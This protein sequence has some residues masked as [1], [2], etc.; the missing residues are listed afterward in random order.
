MVLYSVSAVFKGSLTC[1]PSYCMW[2]CVVAAV[3][4][5]T[6]CPYVCNRCALET[7]GATPQ[8]TSSP[9]LSLLTWQSKDCICKSVSCW[10]AHMLFFF[11]Y[12]LLCWLYTDS[13]ST[14]RTHFSGYNS[15]MQMLHTAMVNTNYVLHLSLIHHQWQ[16]V[17]MQSYDQRTK[18]VSMCTRW[19][20]PAIYILIYG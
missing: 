11:I 3:H 12:L 6:S 7:W 13:T 16:N 20:T 19:Y 17:N 14:A 10:D 4:I 2:T 8:A 5:V 15:Q 18:Y 9:R 1:R